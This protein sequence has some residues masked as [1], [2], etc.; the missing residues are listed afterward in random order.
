MRGRRGAGR[1]TLTIDEPIILVAN[2]PA[3]RETQ[4]TWFH[5]FDPGAR[6]VF[7]AGTFNGWNKEGTRM[8]R[9]GGGEWT[10][11]LELPPGRYEYR[12]VVDGEWKDDPKA[13]AYT[14]NALGGRN[15]VREV[16]G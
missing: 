1:R 3:A 15:A 5:Y 12:F 14:N 4:P 16:A 9:Q 11:E 13:K 2:P 8:L 7:L 10:A 6:E